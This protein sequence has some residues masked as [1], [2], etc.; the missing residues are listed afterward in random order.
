MTRLRSALSRVLRTLAALLLA[1]SIYIVSGVIAA[2]TPSH[3]SLGARASL[4]AVGDTGKIHRPLAA[5]LEG[6]VAVGNDLASEALDHPVDA[7]LL[8][9]DMFYMHG[10]LESELV[11]RIRQNL[12]YPYCHFVELEGP[13]SVEVSSACPKKTARRRTTPIYAVLGNHD[14]GNSKSPALLRDTI[15]EFISN[16]K[17]ATDFAVNREFD[18][19][20]SLI[21]LNSE[22]YAHDEANR[23]AL[24]AALRAAKGP[25]RVIAAHSPIAVGEMGNVPAQ[26]DYSLRVQQWVQGAIEQAGVHVHLYLSGHHHTVQLLEGGGKFGPDLH[27]VVGSGARYRKILAPHPQRRF[28]AERLGFARVDLV[29]DEAVGR[30]VVSLFLSPTIP[31]MRFGGPRLVERWSIGLS[32]ELT[33][34][35]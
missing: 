34:E 35:D 8:L 28:Q 15:P 13:R 9:G 3:E 32:G 30:L 4:L 33:R 20:L 7:L 26:G 1:V 16:W 27:V 29:G 14:L 18:G 17:L 25:W 12:V 22:T 10:L 11:H 24:V 19:G 23:R 31:L 5:L 21:L 2:R 6:Q